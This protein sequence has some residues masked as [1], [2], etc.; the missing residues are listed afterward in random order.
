MK[1][2]FKDIR[3]LYGIV[4]LLLG[5]VGSTFIK[6]KSSI[7]FDL[8]RRIGVACFRMLT[9]HDYLYK[10]LNEIGLTTS[11]SCPLCGDDFMNGG[12]LLIYSKLKEVYT[13]DASH[14]SLSTYI[15]Q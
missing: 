2:K 8:P 9:G 13:G 1:T 11:T 14:F 5:K 3:K 15:G 7:P 6:N 12:H 4:I 10:H